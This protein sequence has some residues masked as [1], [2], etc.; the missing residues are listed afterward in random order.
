MHAN[1]QTLEDFYSAFA[2][3]DADTMAACYAPDAAFDDEVFSLRGHRQVT[4]MWRMLCDATKARGADVW[5]LRVSGLQADAQTGQ[6]HWEADYRFSATGR[7]VHNVI[8]GVFEFNEQGLI[9]RHRDRFDF[10][11]WSRQ[12]LGLVGAVLGWTTFLRHKVSRQAA[13]NLQKYLAARG[14]ESSP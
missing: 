13:A 12:A 5:K 9:T 1:Q 4:G 14:P 10:W 7:M 8:D 3:L 6:A 11:A 2:R